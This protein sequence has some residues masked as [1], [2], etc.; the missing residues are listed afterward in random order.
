[1]SNGRSIVDPWFWWSLLLT[2]KS[3]VS[4]LIES[5]GMETDYFE[6]LY[7]RVPFIFFTFLTFYLLGRYSRTHRCGSYRSANCLPSILL[8]FLRWLCIGRLSGD[9]TQFY[10][11]CCHFHYG[12]HLLLL[13]RENST[14]SQQ[15][16][17]AN[18]K[19]ACVAF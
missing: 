13:C 4:A 5:L 3:Q 8:L 7:P 17:S 2:A 9:K 16:A 12:Q 10:N 14:T 1:M 6:N 11:K 18:T 19:S 15:V